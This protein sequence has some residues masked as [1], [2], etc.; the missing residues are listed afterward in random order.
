[1]LATLV[2]FSAFSVFS[3]DGHAK[4]SIEEHQSS[5]LQ[6]GKILTGALSEQENKDGSREILVKS[7]L[8]ENDEKVVKLSVGNKSKKYKTKTNTVG[9]FL[10]ENGI[11]LKDEDLVIPSSKS[12]LKENDEVLLIKYNERTYVK[13]KNIQYKVEKEISMDVPYGET[14]VEQKGELG[15][16][17][18]KF[19]EKSKNGIILEEEVIS[20]KITKDPIEKKVLIGAKQVVKKEIDFKTVTKKNSSIYKG[21]SKVLNPGEK[22]IKELVYYNNGDSKQFVSSEVV[23]KPKSKVIEVGTKTKPKAT[24]TSTNENTKSSAKYTLA[25]FK[26]N[27]IIRDNGKKFSYYSQSVLPGTGLSIPGRHVSSAGF[28]SDGAGYIVLA[29]NRGIPKGSVISTPFGAMGKV[30]DVCAACDSSW[31]DV[32]VK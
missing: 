31:F 9:E 27:G 11:E 21:D 17:K 8:L 3:V 2:A 24:T 22:G 7:G 12:L 20:E 6:E 19:I 25:N 18:S 32:Y 29:S 26:F 4:A 16:L 23:K 5:Q 1:M 30:Y 14:K 10:E 28:V 13:T 15:K